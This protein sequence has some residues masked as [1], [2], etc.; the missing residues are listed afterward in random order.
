M[1]ALEATGDTNL[2]LARADGLTI[3]DAR[4]GID[5]ALRIEGP[6]RLDIAGNGEVFL[7]ELWAEG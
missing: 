4:L 5:D 3:A 6:A 7:V 2:L 1:A